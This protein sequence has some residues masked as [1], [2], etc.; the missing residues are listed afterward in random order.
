MSAFRS[1]TAALL[2]AAA[3]PAAASPYAIQRID[4]ANFRFMPRQV[5]LSANRPVT[6]IISNA[7]GSGHDF[8]APEFFASSRIIAGAAPGGKIAMPGHATRSITLVPRAGTYRL[9][10]SHFLH[11]SFGMTG[12]IVVR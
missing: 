8:T 11:S 3:S 2:L 7:S 4:L 1:V 5:E 12:T 10:C 9:H 6:L